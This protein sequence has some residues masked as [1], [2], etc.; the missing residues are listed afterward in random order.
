MLVGRLLSASL[1][2][3]SSVYLESYFS[4]VFLYSH[5]VVAAAQVYVQ[6]VKVRTADCFT[7]VSFSFPD[8]GPHPLCLIAAATDGE[9][10]CFII[11]VIDPNKD[12]CLPNPCKNTGRCLKQLNSTFNCICRAEYTGLF[13]EK[14]PC[15]A[16]NWP[17]KHGYCEVNQDSQSCY[18]PLG[19]KGQ[20]CSD[21]IPD[22]VKD[23]L[24]NGSVFTD[25]FIPKEVV[26]VSNKPCVIPFAV[27][28]NYSNPYGPT[29]DFGFV[30]PTIQIN[31]FSTPKEPN[32]TNGT[33]TSEASFTPKLPGNHKVCLQTLNK[34]R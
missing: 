15:L 27:S 30:S 4:V 34:N 29:V 24:N 3:C 19:Y 11:D 28:G 20:T 10:R 25:T 23:P 8:H 6:P 21:V 1:P 33:Y 2:V 31:G 7:D 32:S 18:C 14:G 12:P 26:C 16:T 5:D 17:C 22:D 9:K 13:C